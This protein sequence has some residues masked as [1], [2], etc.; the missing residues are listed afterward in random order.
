M[1]ELQI[2]FSCQKNGNDFRKKKKT[3]HNPQAKKHFKDFK[4]DFHAVD[5]ICLSDQE[6]TAF[7]THLQCSSF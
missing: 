5:K 1:L 2:N 3:T 4:L 6:I 7:T